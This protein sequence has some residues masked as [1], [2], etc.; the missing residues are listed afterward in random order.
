MLESKDD[1]GMSVLMNV[2]SSKNAAIFN[3]AIPFVANHLNQ[4]EVIWNFTLDLE[5]YL[6]EKELMTIRV[7]IGEKRLL[8]L[9][10][11]IR[12]SILVS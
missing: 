1:D 2:M 9:G 11:D 8:V 10:N 6:W 5:P 3:A 4:Q 12:K 7:K